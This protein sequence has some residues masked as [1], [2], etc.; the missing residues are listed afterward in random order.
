MK[1][2]VYIY[3]NGYAYKAVLDYAL[4]ILQYSWF[5]VSKSRLTKTPCKGSLVVKTL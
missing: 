3:T 1:G 4:Q 5:A 2:L